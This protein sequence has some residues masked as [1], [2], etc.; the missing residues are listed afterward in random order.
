[1]FRRLPPKKNL[2]L[3]LSLP[4]LLMHILLRAHVMSLQSKSP[5]FLLREA[6]EEEEEKRERNWSPDICSEHR[7]VRQRKRRR[8]A[9]EGTMLSVSRRGRPGKNSR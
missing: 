4:L 5:T 1:M 9:G 3:S 6:E 2:F 7:C 8:T